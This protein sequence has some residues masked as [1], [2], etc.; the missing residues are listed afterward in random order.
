MTA[1]TQQQ[2]EQHSVILTSRAAICAD[3]CNSLV[4]PLSTGPSTT[5][6]E[7]SRQKL[8]QAGACSSTQ[9][10]VSVECHCLQQDH[11]TLPAGKHTNF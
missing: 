2:T 7:R 8:N 10:P 5:R 3:K 9:Q 1:N 11:H 4:Q 6:Q